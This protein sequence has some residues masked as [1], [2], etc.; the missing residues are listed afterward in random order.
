MTTFMDRETPVRID[1]G[2]CTFRR[3]EVERTLASLSAI[4]VPTG[5]AVR[6]IVADN[7][8]TSSAREVVERAAAS[9]PFP[10]R[11]IHCPASNISLARN[12]CL[13]MAD[14]DFLAFVDD[15]ETVTTGWLVA[16]M[17]TANRTG[18]DVVLGPVRAVYGP[19]APAWM[20][21]AD[22]HSTQ[23]VWVREAIRTGYTCNALL[24]LGT[25]CMSGRRFNLALGR[26]GGEDTEFFTQLYEAGGRLAFA[27]DAWVEERVPPARAR[28]DWLAKRRFRS[29]QTHGRLL[30]R[31]GALATRLGNI[32]LALAKVSY[33]A[34]ATIVLGP[35]PRRRNAYALRGVMHLGVVVGLLG[36]QEIRQYGLTEAEAR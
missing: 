3:P 19:D 31:N 21:A 27:P 13:E 2:I 12:A 10:L 25:P 22:L 23:P 24:R 7:D 35:S 33:C 36:A 14:A 29:G 34:A 28:F 4:D 9:V 26:T 6:V 15:D 20:Q 11:Y 18:A 17:E 8:V 16:L 32:G 30:R 1:V 5:I